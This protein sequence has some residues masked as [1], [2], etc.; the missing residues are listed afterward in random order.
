MGDL[1]SRL[2]NE[3]AKH[4]LE[5]QSDMLN[6]MIDEHNLSLR[7]VV[8]IAINSTATF[9]GQT[10]GNAAHKLGGTELPDGVWEAFID[11]VRIEI[12]D[13]ATF[14]GLPEQSH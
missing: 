2:S 6:D 14:L 10:L 7:D 11:N 4:L 13:S 1:S 9:T 8:Q 3:L 12:T 5:A